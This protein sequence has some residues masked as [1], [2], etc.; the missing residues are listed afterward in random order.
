MTKNKGR[1]RRKRS[2]RKKL[3]DYL[4]QLWSRLIKEK[5]GYKC[6]KCGTNQNLQSAHIFSRT[7]WPTR[8]RIENGMCLC[9]K[10]H[11]YWQPNNPV[12]FTKLAI[13]KRGQETIEALQ[14]EAYQSWDKDYERVRIYLETLEKERPWEPQTFGT[15]A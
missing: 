5:D 15:A 14:K 11:L 12:G 7:H 6:Q 2:D 4:D 3:R 8:W 10:D 1:K 13:E 9:V